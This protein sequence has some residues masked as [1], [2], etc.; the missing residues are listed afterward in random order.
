[1]ERNR[2]ALESTFKSQNPK[3]EI[4][5][6]TDLVIGGKK[7]SG[8]A[9][10]RKKHFLLFHGTILLAFDI[11]LI[12]KYLRMPSKQPAYRH[13]RTHKEFLTNLDLSADAVKEALGKAWNSNEPLEN[14]PHE[15]IALLA[16][17]KYVT[18]EWNFK[19]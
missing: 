10:R 4:A 19:F 17:D 16:R 13:S 5:G 11:L 7:F 3:I 9:Q 2:E 1:M 12:E 14:V 8:N 18:N 15:A 6:H